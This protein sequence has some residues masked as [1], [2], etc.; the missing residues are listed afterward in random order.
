MINNDQVLNMFKRIATESATPNLAIKFGSGDLSDFDVE[1]ITNY[2]DINTTLLDI[3]S[4]SGLTV[5]KLITR[6]RKIVAVEPFEELS[7]YIISS[8][9]ISVV[10]NNILDFQTDQSF[11]VITCFGVM[12]YFNIEEAKVIYKKLFRLL[13]E[14]GTFI[15][16]NQ[17]GVQDDVVVSG[18]SEKLKMDY[19]SEYR[20]LQ[21]EISLIKSCENCKITV[22]DIYPAKHNHWNNTHFYALVVKKIIID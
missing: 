16:K 19:F 12:Q 6:V 9:K 4:G 1:F 7:K 14:N 18:Y 10:N 22:H 11:D 13:K 5:N 17:F 8:P 15:I 3:G 2:T 21:K 20:Y